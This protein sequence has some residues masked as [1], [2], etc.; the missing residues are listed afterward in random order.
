MKRYMN[1][2]GI[3]V[4]MMLTVGC[5]ESPIQPEYPAAEPVTKI[6]KALVENTDMV[7]SIYKDSSYVLTPGL[8]V[9]EFFYLGSHGKTM[10]TWF[11]E[12]DLTQ[13]NLTIENIT[14]G[15]KPL[16][17]GLSE[18][19]TTMIKHVDAPDFFV[20]GGTSTD[21][22]SSTTGSQGVFHH[23]GVCYRDEFTQVVENGVAR[24][25]SFFYLTKD[26]KAYT[27]D[28]SEYAEIASTVEIEEAF[29][30]S[31]QV[32]RGGE[33]PF[34]EEH[35]L[36][37]VHPRTAVGCSPDGTTVWFM[38]VDGRRYTWSNGMY[39]EDLGA[40]FKALGCQ[41][42]INLDGGG[43]STFVVRTQPGHED[44]DRF[45]VMNWP[46]DN[47]GQER[48]LFNGMAIVTKE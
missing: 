10:K 20:W 37:D 28:A 39:L 29:G 22:G 41:S 19:L 44:P 13:E 26:K 12:V 36:S 34:I 16:G 3:A 1:I 46:N 38:V 42:A 23:D 17:S 43:S 47:G 6:G 35:D 11:F 30:G 32:L 21:F 33:I 9:T 15:N 4:S 31:S 7:A 14:P 18:G 27:A 24:P 2:I 8:T 45:T 25:R 40:V 48:P 5:D